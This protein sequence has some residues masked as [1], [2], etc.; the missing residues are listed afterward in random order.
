MFSALVRTCPREAEFPFSRTGRPT[1][2]QDCSELRDKSI[3][4]TR[5]RPHLNQDLNG[6]LSLAILMVSL[7]GFFTI[8]LDKFVDSDPQITVNGSF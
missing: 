4:V 5:S 6:F 7:K 8:G 2:E 3:P 1:E